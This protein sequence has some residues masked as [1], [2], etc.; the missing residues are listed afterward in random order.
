MCVHTQLVLIFVVVVLFCFA[1]FLN[2]HFSN[3]LASLFACVFQELVGIRELQEGPGGESSF[4]MYSGTQGLERG[5]WLTILTSVYVTWQCRFAV[6]H[7]RILGTEQLPC[8]PFVA[9][10]RSPLEQAG[11]YSIARRD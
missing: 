10:R 8:H 1:C 6:F 4:S 7:V 5:K 11:P 3:K 2:K 9:D